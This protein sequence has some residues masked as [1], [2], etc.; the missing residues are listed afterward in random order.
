MTVPALEAMV[1]PTARTVDLDRGLGV[2]DARH[3]LAEAADQEQAVVGA[4][5][6]QHHDDEDVGVGRDGHHVRAE[7]GDHPTRD[8]VGEGDG[9]ERDEGTDRRPVDE[10]QDD[11]DKD[12][13]DAGGRIDAALGLRCCR[14]RGWARRRSCRYSTPAG[15]PARRDLDG[16]QGIL[17]LGLRADGAEAHQRPEPP[18][19]RR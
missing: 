7:E 9:N 13:G 14:R 6:E 17:R 2:L 10:K 16:G 8:Q 11:D 18:A 15:C 3:L 19:C 1:S 4:C 5:P 12:D